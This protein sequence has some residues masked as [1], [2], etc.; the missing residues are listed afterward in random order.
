M[1][2][3]DTYSKDSMLRI[4]RRGL[5]GAALGAGA[6]VLGSQLAGPRH[7]YGLDRLIASAQET[8]PAGSSLSDIQHVVI[9]I[10]ENRSF[11]S[12]FGTY[13]GVRGF[14]DHP[15]GSLGA[16]SQYW[17]GNTPDY[18][19]PFRFDTE[20]TSSDA[21]C[22]NDI[23]H[24]WGSQH[25]S[26]NG[27]RMDS[28]VAVHEAADGAAYGTATMGYWTRD[29]LPFHYALA[30]AFTICDNY[31]CSVFGP[32]YPNRLYSMT[33]T[34]DPDGLAGGPVIT[35]PSAQIGIWSW[36]TYP[37]RLQQ[38]GITW[39]VYSQASTNNNVLPYFSAYDD[40]TSP[41][42]Q[43]GLLPVWPT[44]FQADVLAG[45]LPQVSWVLAPMD[46]D[47][48][49]PSPPTFGAWVISQTLDALLANPEIWAQTAM[50]V[51]YDENGG[52]FDHRPPPTAPPGTAGEYLTVSPLPAIAEG[53]AGPIG[54]GMRV[55]A[56]VV[57][58]F[59][60]GGLV[61]S[62]VFDHTSLLRFL[63]TRFGVEVPNLSGWRRQT[64]GDLTSALNLAA[65]PDNS[66][67]LLPAA[68]PVNE[69]MV[70]E[71]APS[72]G[73]A[74]ISE[75]IGGTNVPPY[76]PPAVQTMPGQEP[77][78]ASRPSGPPKC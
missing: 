22:T 27:G 72:I 45:T 73:Q 71:C 39:K 11:D 17:P 6:G 67:P 16:F 32:T 64:C 54:L 75:T 46:F 29:D 8:C 40:P 24:D 76:A 36:E 23:T 65:A 63:E 33:G 74:T 3:G 57:S 47:E 26:W 2:A 77:G 10:Q 42:A 19:L 7:S 35:N 69:N 44:E 12:Y 66:A 49:P 68:A 58:P 28:F 37:E 13:R 51:T 34:I 55:P 25:Q 59:S 15:A 56:L 38:A 78:T 30:D 53:I 43:N 21:E 14:A 31:H 20:D 41:L 48:H 62:D 50:F 9:L 1:A 60:R 61:S 70:L 5:L 4:S 52:Y 18:L